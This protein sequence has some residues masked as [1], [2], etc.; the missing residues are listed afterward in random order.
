MSRLGT[1]GRKMIEKRKKGL[2]GAHLKTTNEPL[3]NSLAVQRRL[4]EN[5]PL[6]A[7]ISYQKL[8]A[9]ACI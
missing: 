5:P 1:P 2:K 6:T 3:F 7:V 8:L 9:Y 4:R